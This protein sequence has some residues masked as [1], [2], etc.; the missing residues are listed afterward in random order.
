MGSR[1][2]LPTAEA[3]VR[4]TMAQSIQDRRN[5]MDTSIDL[6]SARSIAKRVTNPGSYAPLLLTDAET[7]P[8]SPGAGYVTR[9]K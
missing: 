2:V 1:Y 4:A 5:G 9:A 6:G 3:L 8:D 7:L